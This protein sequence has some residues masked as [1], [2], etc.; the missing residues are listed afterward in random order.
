VTPSSATYA[1]THDSLHWTLASGS[2]CPRWNRLDD[3]N[4][5]F[6]DD[7]S[8]GPPADNP[9]DP[10]PL[11][12]DPRVFRDPFGPLQRAPNDPVLDAFRVA[13]DQIRGFDVEDNGQEVRR[14]PI[15]D[16]ALEMELGVIIHDFEGELEE[17]F[18]SV[19]DAS[20]PLRTFYRLLIQLDTNIM[21]I[22][23]VEGR[24]EIFIPT[25]PWSIERFDRA[26][27]VRWHEALHEHLLANFLPAFEDAIELAVVGSAL[28]SFNPHS[29]EE[30]LLMEE[31][32]AAY[33][34]RDM[35]RY[36]AGAVDF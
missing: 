30:D 4:P 27:N 29:Q 36:R 34:A 20:G 17:T 11:V 28:L 23:T 19:S 24:D 8:V 32:F 21:Y 31:I 9:I 33:L 5:Q 14:P 12:P 25:D 26:R 18:G 7:P 2:R 22:C 1:T 15:P 16:Y 35:T 3:A 10:D 13:R 6:D